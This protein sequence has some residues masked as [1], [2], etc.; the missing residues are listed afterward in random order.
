MS[1]RHLYQEMIIDHGKTPR[2]F[3]KLENA[4]ACQIGHNPLCGDQLTL[5]VYYKKGVIED[6]CFE[7]K[8]CAISVASASLMTETIKG[9]TKSEVEKL[10]T[11]FHRLVTEGKETEA[12]LG[13]LNVFAGVYEFP[14]RVK[15]ATLAW[16]TLRA[17]LNE[18]INPVSTE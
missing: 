8:G 9:K 15:C 6:I 16:H 11:D 5:Y 3:G 12:S 7:G 4:N 13:K 10:L 17:V 2:N 18:E 14:V 1:L